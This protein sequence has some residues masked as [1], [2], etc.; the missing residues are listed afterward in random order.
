MHNPGQQHEQKCIHPIT[1]SGESKEST[2]LM[3]G[4]N[5]GEPGVLSI[6]KLAPP[7]LPLL[8]RI[9]LDVIR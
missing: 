5:G 6:S 2:V 3:A 8:P 4:V 9:K 7:M 1:G